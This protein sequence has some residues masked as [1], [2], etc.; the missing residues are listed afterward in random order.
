MTTHAH[1][2]VGLIVS[3]HARTRF[4]VQQKDASYP[5][6]PLAYSL[7]GGACEPDEAPAQALARELVEELEDAAHE[8]LAVGPSL[9]G[10]HVV[11]PT[12]FAYS[13]FEVQITNAQIDLLE[14]APVLEGERG[15]VVSRAQLRSLPYIW[16]LEV[17]I[18]AYLEHH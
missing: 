1:H 14:R 11:G 13:L 9:V 7:F 10:E 16:G 5:H 3:N 15:A 4:Y 8:L 18:A 2:G 17:V 6:Y 12:G